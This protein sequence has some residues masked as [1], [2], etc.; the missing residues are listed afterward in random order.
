MRVSDGERRLL[1]APH[2]VRFAGFAATTPQ[3]Q[4]MGWQISAEQ[5][6]MG[7]RCRIALRHADLQVV[8]ITNSVSF[9]HLAIRG[10]PG[11]Y[12]DPTR[13]HVLTFD[14]VRMGNLETYVHQW[15]MDEPIRPGAFE[16]IDAKTQFV[17]GRVDRFE[18]LVIFAPPLVETQELI[19]D[20]GKVSAILA[21]LVEAQKPEQERIRDRQRL[22]ESREGLELGAEPRRK[23]H[24]QILSIAA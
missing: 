3:L 23:F 11:G 5:D 22:R 18:D 4:Q 15:C 20:E 13:D 17:S 21:K 9:Y 10:A 16:S 1:S 2:R 24:A 19:V 7:D 12:I 14:V 6:F 8:A